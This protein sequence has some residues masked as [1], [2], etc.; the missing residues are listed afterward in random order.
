[1]TPQEDANKENAEKAHVGL[2]FKNEYKKVIIFYL[3]M[4]LFIFRMVSIAIPAKIAHQDQH[5]TSILKDWRGLTTWKS[6]I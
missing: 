6:S 5:Q 4:N 2:L 3:K 1:M